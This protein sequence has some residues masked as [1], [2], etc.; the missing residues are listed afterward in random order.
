MIVTREQGAEACTQLSLIAAKL[1]YQLNGM[2]PQQSQV[3]HFYKGVVV[4]TGIHL[5]DAAHILCSN[6]DEHISSAFSIFRI[7][8]DDLLRACYVY[9]C[10]DR[11]RALDDITAKAFSD[12]FKTWKEAARLNRTL[13]LGGD[14]TDVVVN[15]ERE[16]FIASAA[17]SRY[18]T[19]NKKGELV[20][21]E[22]INSRVLVRAIE[23]NPRVAHYS[24]GYVLFKQMS[25]YIHY[26]M[27]TYQMDRSESRQKEI[28]FIDEVIFL[29]YHLLRVSHEV[30]A[31]THA[32]LEWPSGPADTSLDRVS[33]IVPVPVK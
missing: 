2:P 28:G 10:S 32:D 19:T 11:K 9:S 5:K 13:N 15:E 20:L 16:K 24:R 31:E 30:L 7:V 12:Y 33:Y 26:S 6:H 22:V 8:L 21:R 27:L 17:G 23:E 29:V 1:I 14:M 4:R 25:H 3:N 18:T